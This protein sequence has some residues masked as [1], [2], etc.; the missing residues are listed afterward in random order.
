[1][2]DDLHGLDTEIFKKLKM[3]GL[4]MADRDVIEGLDKTTISL[5]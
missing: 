4:V 1:M 5:P 2:Q 3:N